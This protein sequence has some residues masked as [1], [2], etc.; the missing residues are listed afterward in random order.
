[1]QELGQ[2]QIGLIW[3]IKIQRL[4]FCNEQIPISIWAAFGWQQSEVILLL[5][6]TQIKAQEKMNKTN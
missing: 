6:K 1:M 2:E 3:F 5:L 4:A